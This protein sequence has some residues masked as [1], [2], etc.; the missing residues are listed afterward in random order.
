MLFLLCTLFK[1]CTKSS[2]RYVIVVH[3][4][5]IGGR[6]KP[7]RDLKTHFLQTEYA[8]VGVLCDK[9][10]RIESFSVYNRKYDRV[11][12]SERADVIMVNACD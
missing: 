9:G 7:N 10:L 1:T 6:E 3:F 11:Q 5:S 12:F 2:N 4:K 8:V